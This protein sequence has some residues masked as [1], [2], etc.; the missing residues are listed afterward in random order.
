MVVLAR[1]E[2]LVS[3]ADGVIGV[4]HVNGGSPTLVGPNVDHALDDVACSRVRSVAPSA[5]EARKRWSD[6]SR[7]RVFGRGRRL[8]SAL[9]L[10]RLPRLKVLPLVIGPPFGVTVV[11]LP[12]RIPLPSKITIRMLPRLDV[13]ESLGPDPGPEEGYRLVTSPLR[14][15]LTGL[16]DKRRLPVIG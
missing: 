2:P 11:D 13:R 8:A 14:R 12:G 7:R 6:H 1:A 4:A 16:F 9:Q 15:T 5:H 3:P 10:N